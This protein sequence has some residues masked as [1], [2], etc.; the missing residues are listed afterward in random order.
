M[1]ERKRGRPFEAPRQPRCECMRER[2]E[3]GE[4]IRVRVSV[5]PES[6]HHRG[7]QWSQS[8]LDPQ[9]LGRPAEPGE[10]CH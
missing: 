9:G 8:D 7:E 2:R 4:G 6:Q 5:E 3:R 10:G 1:Q